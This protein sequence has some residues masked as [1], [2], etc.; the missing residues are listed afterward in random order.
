MGE[1]RNRKIDGLRG[2]GALMVALNHSFMVLKVPEAADI[3]GKNILEFHDWSSKINQLLMLLGNGGLA[4]TLFFLI[5]GLV[6]GNSL[7]RRGV[8]WRGLGKFY[9]RRIGRLYPIYA[10][11][12]LAVAVYMTNGFQYK[13]YPT[14]G[15]WFNWWMNFKMDWRELWLN[16]SMVHLYVGGVT[17]TLRVLVVATIFFPV[18]YWVNRK[19]KWWADVLTAGLLYWL[20]RKFLHWSDFLDLNYLYMIYM[21][22]A[23]PKWRWLWNWLE[24]RGGRLWLVL[25]PLIFMTWGIRYQGLTAVNLITEALIIWTVLGLV[26]YG[27][28]FKGFGFLE[29]RVW[30]F[31]GSISYEFYLAHFSVLYWLAKTG[32]ERGWLEKGSYLGWHMGLFL[33]STI[34]T[35]LLVLGLRKVVWGTNKLSKYLYQK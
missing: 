35:I 29:G 5:S 19:T 14:S 2:L 33:G 30:Q 22:L 26:V 32:F 20:P 11:M 4:V 18:F 7:D 27:E 23:I 31:M 10:V 17:W 3:W 15:A 6:L 16:L 28:G 9:W 13:T 8:D 12:V 21:G 24:K 34:L 25:V 1:G